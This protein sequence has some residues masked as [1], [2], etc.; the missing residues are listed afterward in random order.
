MDSDFKQ[1]RE[2]FLRAIEAAE[3]PDG[4]NDEQEKYRLKQAISEYELD[5][6]A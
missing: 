2:L 1:S 3:N 4:L 5:I 6:T